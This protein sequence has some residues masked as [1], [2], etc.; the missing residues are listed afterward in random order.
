VE[1]GEAAAASLRCNERTTTKT[2]RIPLLPPTNIIS[3]VVAA[4]AVAQFVDDGPQAI[5]LD[6]EE[7]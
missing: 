6:P 2:T 3:N 5:K 4:A 1:C 7:R